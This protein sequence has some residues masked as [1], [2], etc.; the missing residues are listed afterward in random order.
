VYDSTEHDLHH[1]RTNVNYGFPTTHMDRLHGTF[2][3]PPAGAN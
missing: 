1:S 2:V 3:K